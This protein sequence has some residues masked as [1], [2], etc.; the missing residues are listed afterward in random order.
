MFNLSGSI[1]IIP[2]RGGSKG[3]PRKS[4]RP[5]AGKPM[6]YYAIKACLQSTAIDEVVVSTDDDEIAL[7]AERFGATVLMRDASLAQDVTTLDPVIENAVLQAEAYFS[8]TFKWV[9]TIQPTSPLIQGHDLDRAKAL[10]VAS[11]CDSVITVV[12]D[13]H[14]CWTKKE[15]VVTPLYSKRVNRQQLPENYRETGAII[16]CTRAQL[17]QG[18][19]IG[20]NV[21][22]LEMPAIRSFDID[23]FSDLYL[24]E[25]IL[26]RKKI[27][28]TVV[29]Y[30]EVGLGHAFRAVMLAHELVNYDLVFLCDEKS[31]LAADYIES[32]NYTVERCSEGDFLTFIESVRPSLVINDL[33][34]T[35][36]HYIKSLK[37]LNLN[38][39]N[40]EDLGDGARYADL[41]VNALYPHQQSDSKS[42]LV[43]TNYFC[44]REEFLYPPQIEKTQSNTLNILVTFGGVDEGD[45]TGRVVSLLASHKAGFKLTVVTGP[46]YAHKDQLTALV[47][48]LPE[49]AAVE[50]V[51]NTKRISDYMFAADFAITSAG[52]TVLE[53]AST[54]T[55]VIAICQNHREMTHTF[56]N[57]KNGVINLGFRGD[58]SDSSI[59]DAV[60]RLLVDNVRKSLIDNMKSLDLTKGKSRVIDKLKK[61]VE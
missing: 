22:L 35:E 25:S 50:V 45:L 48:T 47:A 44:L 51:V 29:G 27:L 39:V 14:L 40:F 12:D 61:L 58:V 33:L 6:I 11:K 54:L 4:I 8:S 28:F 10:F 55:P 42:L 18:T 7:L 21:E 41:V 26:N 17:S 1:A 3:I 57:E 16:A 13:R 19:R 38:V 15:G 32:F 24:C 37:K 46:G 9:Y 34:D 53:L 36:E 49:K 20:H 23:N 5:I 2:A 30:P 56:A 43:G 31:Q 60:D 52:R 59:L